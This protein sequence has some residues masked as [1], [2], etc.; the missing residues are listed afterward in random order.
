MAKKRPRQDA[1]KESVD[2]L[3]DN[4]ASL[5]AMEPP[6]LRLPSRGLT[7]VEGWWL[8]VRGVALARAIAQF[9]AIKRHQEGITL[10]FLDVQSGPGTFKVTRSEGKEQYTFPGAAMLA[11]WQGSFGPEQRFDHVYAF[12]VDPEYRGAIHA[13]LGLLAEQLGKSGIAPPG[14]H[15]IKA[16]VRDETIDPGQAVD[17]AIKDIRDT[18]GKFY[19]YLGF[20]DTDGLGVKFSTIKALREKLPYGDLI[21]DYDA[22]AVENTLAT[23]RGY[24]V[25][26][27]FFGT[28]VPRGDVSLG[29]KELYVAQLKNAGFR[30]VEAISASPAGT[31]C[32]REL[33]FCSRTEKPGWIPMV[34][35]LNERLSGMTAET[36][37]GFWR[38]TGRKAPT[39]LDMLETVKARNPPDES[40]VHGEA[41]RGST[42]DIDIAILQGKEGWVRPLLA[43]NDDATWKDIL[44]KNVFDVLKVNGDMIVVKKRISNTDLVPKSACIQGKIREKLGVSALE[45]R[46]TYLLDRRSRQ[47]GP[48]SFPGDGRLDG[49][50]FW[51]QF[52]KDSLQ[53]GN[54]LFLSKVAD[55]MKVVII[56]D[57]FQQLYPIISF[58]KDYYKFYKDVRDSNVAIDIP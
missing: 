54:L 1:F 24:K 57:H 40:G 33:L 51:L 42:T 48:A 5:K 38:A 22:A 17:E 23:P 58:L 20:I 9:L 25:L 46:N 52:Y 4:G 45:T 10:D 31:P 19:H 36:I 29:L 2:E 32:K 39:L 7:E 53:D 14:L 34:A 18:H 44:S 55:A 37:E 15:V 6:E 26:D 49:T 11:L 12:D 41:R 27:S 13:R 30:S 35:N 21:V 16:G 3:L 8:A 56:I 50:G 43:G 47:F 28:V